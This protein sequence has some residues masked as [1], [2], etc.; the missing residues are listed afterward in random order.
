[1]RTIILAMLVAAGVGLAGAPD[2]LALPSSG[3]ALRAAADADPLIQHAYYRR[4]YR[5][6]RRY[7]YYRPYYRRYGYYRPYRYYHRYRYYRPYY[8]YRYYYRS[9]DRSYGP[10]FGT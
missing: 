2:S 9:Y 7:G 8:R 10:A 1:M 5:P 3:T 6:Y 4:Y